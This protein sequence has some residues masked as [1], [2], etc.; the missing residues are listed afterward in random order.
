MKDYS[1]PPNSVKGGRRKHRDRDSQQF[2]SGDMSSS[3]HGGGSGS[4]N[5]E[6]NL[7]LSFSSEMEGGGGRSVD[8][9]SLGNRNSSHDFGP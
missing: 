8:Q 1:R 5:N 7:I 2:G 9:E 4:Q 6:N 3:N